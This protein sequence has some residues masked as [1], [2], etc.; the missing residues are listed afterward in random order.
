MLL[1]CSVIV[2]PASLTPLT[3]IILAEICHEAGVPEGVVNIVPGSGSEVGDYFVEHPEVDKVAFTGSTPIGK[4]IMEKASHTLKRV[5][6][7][8]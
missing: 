8:A 7:R 6:L 5:T 2:K 1:V 4:D 3:A